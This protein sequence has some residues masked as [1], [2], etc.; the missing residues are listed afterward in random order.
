MQS[1]VL[2]TTLL[3]CSLIQMSLLVACSLLIIRLHLFVILYQRWCNN[4]SEYYMRFV[5]HLHWQQLLLYYV[6]TDNNGSEYYCALFF[7][8]HWPAADVCIISCFYYVET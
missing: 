3:Y 4:G 1:V 5:F 8:L 6:E 7:H 2:A